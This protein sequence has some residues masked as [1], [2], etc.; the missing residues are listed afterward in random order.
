[1]MAPMAISLK[2]KMIEI[3]SPLSAKRS[4]GRVSQLTKPLY[5]RHMA[6]ILLTR[7][8]LRLFT[9]SSAGGKEG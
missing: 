3:F 7:T 9:L 1:M 2:L 5:R 4:D 6:A 8:S